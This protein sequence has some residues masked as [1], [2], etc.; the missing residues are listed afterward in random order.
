MFL[1]FL[2]YDKLSICSKNT[3]KDETENNKVELENMNFAP[4]S[5]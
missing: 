1:C 3:V 5:H 2:Y 4:I